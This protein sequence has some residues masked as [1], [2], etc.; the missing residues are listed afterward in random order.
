MMP[1]RCC[2]REFHK[3]PSGMTQTYF[4]PA[5]KIGNCSNS[6]SRYGKPART[7]PGPKRALCSCCKLRE[8]EQVQHTLITHK[9][10]GDIK[11]IHYRQRRT[12]CATCTMLSC[13]LRSKYRSSA[14]PARLHKNLATRRI[15]PVLA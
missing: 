12:R 10:R 3:N 14:C 11:P 4:C 1:C 6:L 13:N 8:I 9:Y 5:C 15:D 2:A 7:C